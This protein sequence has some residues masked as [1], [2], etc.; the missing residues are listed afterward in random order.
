MATPEMIMSMVTLAVANYSIKLSDNEVDIKAELF[1]Q[2]FKDVSDHVF[3]RAFMNAIKTSPYFPNVAI[4]GNAIKEIY[5]TEKSEKKSYKELPQAV[6]GKEFVQKII[7]KAK[8]IGNLAEKADVS[9]VRQTALWYFKGITDEEIRLSL[10]EFMELQEQH[11]YCYQ[12]NG[13][14]CKFGGYNYVP[15]MVNGYVVLNMAKCEKNKSRVG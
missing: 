6:A 12:C 2:S 8:D 14:Y 13:G 15:Q 9:K 1:M 11:E 5:Q 10:L 4:V 3:Q 7:N